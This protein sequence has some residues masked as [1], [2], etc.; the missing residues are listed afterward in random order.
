ML[1]FNIF[2]F[3]IFNFDQANAGYKLTENILNPFPFNA[4]LY[5]L[6]TP[7]NFW[8]T[9]VFRGYANGTSAGNLLK[10]TIKNTRECANV[11]QNLKG[12]YQNEAH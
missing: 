10:S 9:N 6:K 11:L 12:R 3:Y 8:F 7:E 4:V 1:T 2:V 5:S